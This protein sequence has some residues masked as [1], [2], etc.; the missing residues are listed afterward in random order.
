MSTCEDYTFVCPE[1][2]QS[3]T[4]NA[5]MRE[6]LVENGCVICGA[7]VTQSAFDPGCDE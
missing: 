5:S 6:A 3:I 1:C 4:V 7:P 2:S